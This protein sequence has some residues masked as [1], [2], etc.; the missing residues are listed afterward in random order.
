MPGGASTLR[1]VFNELRYLVRYGTASPALR[2]PARDPRGPAP[3][4]HP[5][6]AAQARRRTHRLCV[7]PSGLKPRHT[8]MPKPSER[9]KT[10]T[11]RGRRR[12]YSA[13]WKVRLVKETR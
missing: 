4:R 13:E 6:P 11:G 12:R 9:V 8:P 7:T 5:H 10:I 1:A 2:G 3:R